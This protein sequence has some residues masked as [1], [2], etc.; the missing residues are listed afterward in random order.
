M[1]VG[2]VLVGNLQAAARVYVRESPRI[3]FSLGGRDEF[4]HNITLCRAEERLALAV[5]RPTAI[6]IIPDFS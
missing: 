4:I 6:C 5:V 1:P 3:D 2:T